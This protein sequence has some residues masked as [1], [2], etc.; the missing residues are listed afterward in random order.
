MEN[1]NCKKLILTAAGSWGASEFTHSFMSFSVSIPSLAWPYE[2]AGWVPLVIPW[3]L[4]STHPSGE[5]P[6]QAGVQLRVK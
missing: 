4:A 2:P 5:R 1:H 6:G 3:M